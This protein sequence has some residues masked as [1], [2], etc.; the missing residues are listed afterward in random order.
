MRSSRYA[1]SQ[2][3]D[4]QR[5]FHGIAKSDTLAGYVKLLDSTIKNYDIIRSI[6]AKPLL[7]KLTSGGFFIAQIDGGIYAV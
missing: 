5:E 6:P 2:L 7:C 3:L 4:D 1:A